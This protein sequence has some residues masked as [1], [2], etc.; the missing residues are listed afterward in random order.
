MP[1][2]HLPAAAREGIR[3]FN[4]GYY[5]EAHDLLEEV[6]IERA[7]REKTFYQ[8]LIQ[9]A[10]GFYKVAMQN[11]GGARS[12]VKKGLEK[13]RAVRDLATPLDLERLITEAEAALARIDEL[14][15]ARIAEFDLATLPRIHH[16]E[17]AAPDDAA[18]RDNQT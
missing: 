17:P 4:D 5:F 14:G 10:S 15:Q 2:V 16:R 3:L 7:G 12:L 6:W 9:I 1:P 8:G 13:L 18:P 11:Q